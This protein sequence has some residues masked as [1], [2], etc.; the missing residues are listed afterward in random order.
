MLRRVDLSGIP[1]G[2]S[3]EPRHSFFEILRVEVQGVLWWIAMINTPNRKIQVCRKNVRLQRDAVSDFPLVLV[4]QGN[5]HDACSPIVLPSL[6]LVLGYDLVGSDLQVFIRIG[7]QLC[8]E[9]FWPIIDVAPAKPR[10]WG[11]SIDTRHG[12]NFLPVV[13]RQKKCQ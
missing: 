5:V 10:K 13:S 8:K 7:G 2:L 4:S 6:Q 3:L 11:N 12:T 9:M 1:A